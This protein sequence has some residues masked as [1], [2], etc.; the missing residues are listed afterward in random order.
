MTGEST[1]NSVL[2][3][4]RTLSLTEKISILA[5]LTKIRITILVVLTT[6]LGYLLS[7]Q[8]FELNLI[9]VSAGIFFL[10][11]GASVFNHFQEKD[12]DLL[13]NRTKRRPLPAKKI[14][15]KTVLI[16]AFT[17]VIIGSLILLLFVNII[18]FCIGLITLIWYNFVYTPLKKKTIWAII[19]GSFVGALPPLAGY[20]ANQHA[21]LSWQIIVVSVYLFIWQI[22][23][24]WIL[25]LKFEKDYKKANF[26]VITD[27]Y[28]TQIIKYV[29]VILSIFSILLATAASFF[30]LDYFVL[31]IMLFIT[32]ALAIYS[33]TKFLRKDLSEKSLTICFITINF[34]TLIFILLVSTNQVLNKI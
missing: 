10:A 27:R 33:I 28:S 17:L 18:S 14:Q 6:I 34:F 16:I 30:L 32:M 12:S 24:F 13:M 8:T 3:S 7:A 21:I 29:S 22:P 11:C 31:L 1:Y 20:F 15:P 19:P 5:E 26:P 9:F 23:H 2:S 25:L 4:L